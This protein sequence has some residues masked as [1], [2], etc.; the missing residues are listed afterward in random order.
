MDFSSHNPTTSNSLNLAARNNDVS[1]VRRLLKIINPNCVDNRG[2]T[3]LHE[4]A[5]SDS[6]ECLILILKHPDCRPLSRTHEGHTA[7]YLACRNRC[8][9]KTIKVMLE[10]VRNIATYCSTEGATPLHIVSEQGRVEIIQLLINHGAIIDYQDFDGDTPLHQA[11]LGKEPEAVKLLLSAGANPQTKNKQLFT[12]FHL[13]CGGTS[14]QSVANI[15]HYNIDVNKRTAAGETPLMIALRGNS[16][17]VVY[18][19]LDNGANPNLKNNKD[20]LALDVAIDIGYSPVFRKLLS[21]TD[22]D[23]INA[24]IVCRACKPHYYA[25]DI[26]KALLTSDLGPKF[27]KFIEPWPEIYAETIDEFKPSYLTHAPLNAYFNI[28]EHI[29][30]RSCE[31][32]KEY[33]NLFLKRG[34]SVNALEATE[35]PP[36]VYIHY[37]NHSVCFHEV[38]LYF[39]LFIFLVVS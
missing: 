25:F 23:V 32:F 10:T 30:K 24:N 13:A 18:F 11:C 9:L 35:C 36:L 19:L 17:Y 21:V 7:L 39:V 15:I 38:S 16:E 31:T 2:W 6:Y 27:F 33:F 8:S 14:L 26:L 5:N 1:N 34:V 4:A 29:Y 28:C 22:K 20:K 37:C 12:P 3:C